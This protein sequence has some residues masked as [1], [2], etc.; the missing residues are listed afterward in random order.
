[1]G[2]DGSDSFGAQKNEHNEEE[3]TQHMERTQCKLGLHHF[4]H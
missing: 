3:G 4:N 1:M 2:V